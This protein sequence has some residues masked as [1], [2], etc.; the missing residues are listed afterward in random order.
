MSKPSKE[1]TCEDVQALVA[2]VYN[3]CKE[4]K[5]R[6]EKDILESDDYDA[7]SGTVDYCEG[8]IELA[9]QIQKIID[10]GGKINAR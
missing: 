10:T 8:V 7:G 2:Q 9:N 4:E 5:H 3:R 1:L 6:A